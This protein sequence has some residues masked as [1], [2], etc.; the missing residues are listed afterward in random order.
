MAT[1]EITVENI[2]ET[3]TGNDI[4]LLDFWASWCGPCRAFAPVFENVSEKNPEIVFGKVDTDAQQELAQAFQISSIPTLVIFREQIP[5]FAQPGAMNIAQLTEIIEKVGQL[6]MNEVR[7]EIAQQQASQ[8]AAEEDSQG[9]PSAQ[10]AQI[11]G[12][13]A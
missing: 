6:D 4:V 1:Q 8:Q 2:N 12:D 10:A 9:A 5:I 7:A 3:I 11:S 13:E